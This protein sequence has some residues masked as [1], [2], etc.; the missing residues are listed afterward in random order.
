[1]R[2]CCIQLRSGRMGALADDAFINRVQNIFRA[3]IAA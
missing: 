1:M 2:Q 3:A